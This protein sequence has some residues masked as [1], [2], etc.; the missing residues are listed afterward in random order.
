MKS[1]S[2]LLRLLES[3]RN[4][5]F[6]RR[7][8][9]PKVNLPPAAFQHAV[10]RVPSTPAAGPGGAS[11]GAGNTIKAETTGQPRP[12]FPTRRSMLTR[13]RLLAARQSRRNFPS[14]PS[15]NAEERCRARCQPARR[16]D[17]R[18][19]AEAGSRRPAKP[20]LPSP[21]KRRPAGTAAPRAG[22]LDPRG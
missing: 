14:S 16:T 18:R 7:S 15:Q 2:A 4:L 3:S 20:P 21:K 1:P 11:P 5:C 12:V 6:A 9:S 19:P 17:R 10:L 22:N 13:R 8:L